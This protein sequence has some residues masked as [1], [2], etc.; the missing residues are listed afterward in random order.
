MTETLSDAFSGVESARDANGRFGSWTT[1]STV[2]YGD[3][4][5]SASVMGLRLAAGWTPRL[6]L[7]APRRTP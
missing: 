5:A 7:A 4:G 3:C 2:I 6:D 1:V